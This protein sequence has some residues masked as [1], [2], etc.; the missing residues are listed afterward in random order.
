MTTGTQ[1]DT[2]PAAGA[3][4]GAEL[5]YVVKDGADAQTTT[6]A[7]ADL[8]DTT[9]DVGGVVVV[10]TTAVPIS[11]AGQARPAVTGPVY[12]L[13]AEGVAPTHAV[14]GDIIWTENGA[15][16][17]FTDATDASGFGFMVDEDDMVS[18]SASRFPSQQ[19]VVA[20]VA[21][22]GG[23]GGGG[24]LDGGNAASPGIDIIDGGTA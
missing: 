12:W 4:T 20:Y 7:I 14:P 3:L 24:G 15:D 22:H 5:A 11:S 13:M 6:Q 23:G 9:L 19:S 17:I 10:G 8:A 18:N 16:P 1:L 21:T 2:L